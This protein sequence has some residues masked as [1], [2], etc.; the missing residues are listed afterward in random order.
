MLGLWEHPATEIRPQH[1]AFRASLDDVLH[2]AVPFLQTRNLS[3]RNFL[4]DGTERPMVFGWMPALAIY[5]RDPDGH[6][7]EFINPPVEQAT[8]GSGIERTAV[9]IRHE[10]VI[11]QA[12][13]RR[14]LGA[15]RRERGWTPAEG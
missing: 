13:R 8:S 5:F 12:M 11:R 1:V 14:R 6:S 3:P 10:P 9:D 2:R 7:L 15:T 4:N